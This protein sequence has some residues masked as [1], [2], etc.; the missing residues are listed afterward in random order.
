MRHLGKFLACSTL[1]VTAAALL[2]GPQF[3]SPQAP[4]MPGMQHVSASA[5]EPVP[6]YHAQAAQGELPPTMEPSLFTDKLIF[7]A[8][9]VAG[10]VKKVLYQQPCYCHCDRS[11]G[12][13][14]LLDCFVSRHGSGC[15]ICMKEAFY[16]YEQTRRGRTPTQIRD[17]I[18]RGDWQKVDIAKYQRDYL[19]P[20]SK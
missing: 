18:M 3:A 2:L 20:A 5:D 8:Y 7:N 1:L 4:Q 19:P 9:V 16:S 10:R 11:Q 17:G 15:D 13:G 6:A 14:S 12:H